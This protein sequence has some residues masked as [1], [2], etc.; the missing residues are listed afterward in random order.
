MLQSVFSVLQ[1]SG[2]FMFILDLVARCSRRGRR[3]VTRRHVHMLL[4]YIVTSR[5][6]E[7]LNRNGHTLRLQ[8]L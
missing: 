4:G 5:N 2:Q 3:F 8:R 6:A 1:G 7:R